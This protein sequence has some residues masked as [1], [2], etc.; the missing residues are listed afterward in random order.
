MRQ[1]SY[2]LE[3]NASFAKISAFLMFSLYIIDVN[4][5]MVTSL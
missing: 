5:Y 3:L 1:E 2:F 4:K